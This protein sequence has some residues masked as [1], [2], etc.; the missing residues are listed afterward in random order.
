MEL[1]T[2]FRRRLLADGSVSG[3]VGR[4]VFKFSLMESVDGTG[5][6]AIVV[7]RSNGWAVPSDRTTGE[8]PLLAVDCYADCD[9]DAAGDVV[10][11]NAIDKA[12]AMYRVVDPLI[13][14]LRGVRVGPG[15]EDPGLMVVSAQRW[16]EPFHRTDQDGHPGDPPLG[17]AAC[18]TAVYALNVV[19]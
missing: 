14:G 5:K 11:R 19:H 1:E 12:Y 8:Y 9:R 2:A 10:A 18:V 3:Y 16:S 4:K 6:R 13:H 15:G 17:D 7:R